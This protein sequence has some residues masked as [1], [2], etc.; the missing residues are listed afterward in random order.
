MTLGP[1][2]LALSYILAKIKSNSQVK[3]VYRGMR[4][5]KSVFAEQFGY[6]KDRIN[7]TDFTEI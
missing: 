7:N 1:Y 4:I 3:F 5:P 2:A 6:E